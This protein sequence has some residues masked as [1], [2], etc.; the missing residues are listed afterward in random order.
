MKKL[1]TIILLLPI[2]AFAT[3]RG[4]ET[5]GSSTQNA[6][7]SAF[8]STTVK[9]STNSTAISGSMA[10]GGSAY[11]NSQGGRGGSASVNNS[12]RGGDGGFAV[13]EGNSV[14]FNQVQQTPFAYAPGL[15]QSF[16][17]DNCANTASV[18]VSAGFGALAAGAPVESDSCNRRK[19]VTLW[20]VTGQNR[21]ACER[22]TDDNANMEAMKR[23]GMDCKTLTEIK[24]P[25]NV[26]VNR[27]LTVYDKMDYVAD[28]Q[29]QYLNKKL[30]K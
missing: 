17:Q 28:K 20:L 22:M 7:L 4:Y 30:G 14:R 26:P 24:P 5:S 10:T 8:Q 25:V 11:S 23:A 18:G 21:I 1:L 9:S 27:D 19:D 12:V 15:A 16:S 3:G 2:T 29:I 6:N 13:N